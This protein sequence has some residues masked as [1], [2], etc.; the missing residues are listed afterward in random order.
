MPTINMQVDENI[1]DY[2]NMKTNKATLNQ[3][4]ENLSETQRTVFASWYLNTAH[5]L[6]LGAVTVERP[7]SVTDCRLPNILSSQTHRKEINI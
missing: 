7:L 5:Q 6:S 2:I 1:Q 3:E 4:I